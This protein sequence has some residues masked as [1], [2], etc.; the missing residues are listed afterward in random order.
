MSPTYIPS[1]AIIR[2]GRERVDEYVDDD[3]W[4]GW[5]VEGFE[6]NVDAGEKLGLEGA[7]PRT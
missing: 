4:L 7:S 1:F 2:W 6:V 3:R 5:M